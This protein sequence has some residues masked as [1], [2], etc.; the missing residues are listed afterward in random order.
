MLPLLTIRAELP[1]DIAAIYALTAAAFGRSEEARL[2]DL[3]RASG[4]LWLSLL[5]ELDGEVV[6]HTAFSP[7]TIEMP[8]RTL[9]AL[10]LGPVAVIPAQQ[11]RGIGGMVIRHGLSECAKLGHDVVFLLG[12]PSYYPRLGFRPAKALGVHWVGDT[13]DGTCDP[14]M[15]HERFA[16]ALENAL[17]GQRGVFHFAPQFNEM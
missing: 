5:A 16:R 7:A 14:F 11:K 12:H 10:A 3:L 6:A 15:V 8:G 17:N 9:Q 13:G 2:N 4:N 1:H